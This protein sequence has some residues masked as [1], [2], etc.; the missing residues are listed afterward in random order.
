MKHKMTRLFVGNWMSFGATAFSTENLFTLLS[1]TNGSGK[2]SICDAFSLIYYAEEF[3]M[4]NYTS[5][6]RRHAAGAIHWQT[7]F[8]MLRPGGTNSYII[9]EARDSNDRTY[10]QGLFMYS[11]ANSNKVDRRV[12][13][14]GEGTLEGIGALDYENVKNGRITMATVYQSREQAFTAFF[15]R[16]GYPVETFIR[17][18]FQGMNSIT[19]FRQMNR[20]ILSNSGIGAKSLSDYA[21]DNIFPAASTG[22]S[23]KNIQEYQRELDRLSLAARQ[24]EDKAVFLEKIISMG[25]DN[26][27]AINAAN[28][29]ERAIAH[30]N[31]EHYETE[32]KELTAQIDGCMERIRDSEQRAKEL[33]DKA[34]SL[35]NE[36]S[37]LSQMATPIDSLRKELEVKE[38][39]LK[40]VGLRLE[41]HRKYI[42]AKTA[43]INK[44]PDPLMIDRVNDVLCEME[45]DEER[46]KNIYD[47]DRRACDDVKERI[48][49]LRAAL[50]GEWTGNG[51]LAEM[52]R[53]AAILKERIR[54][55]CPD[56]RPRFLYECIDGVTDPEWQEAVERLLGN[57]RFG[58]IVTGRYYRRA[59]E[60]QHG[61]RG[62]KR[63]VIVLNTQRDAGKTFTK[64]VPSV[65]RFNDERAEKYVASA[66]GRYVLCETAE[67]YGDAEYAIRKNG[68]TK[69]PNRSVL[70]GSDQH[71]TK[72][73]GKEAIRREIDRLVIRKD[74]LEVVAASSHEDYKRIRAERNELQSLNASY[75][76]LAEH[77]DPLAERDADVLNKRIDDIRQRIT[78]FMNS[79][80]EKEKQAE[81]RRLSGQI[82]DMEKERSSVL[83]YIATS[84]NEMDECSK[85]KA[86]DEKRHNEIVPVVNTLGPLTELDEAVIEKNGWRTTI[87]LVN[88]NQTRQDVV[89]R[90]SLSRSM[91]NEAFL[92][93]KDIM[94]S[95]PDAPMTIENEDQLGWFINESDRIAEV[96]MD[97]SNLQQ[98]ER[99]K[100]TLK[101]QFAGM[102]HS[103]HQDLNQ[104]KA[105]RSKFNSFLPKYRIGSCY[106]RLGPIQIRQNVE[107]AR[108]MELAEKQ[109]AGGEQLTQ[110][111]IRYIDHVFT[112]IENNAVKGVIIDPFDYRRYIT[113][114]MEYR[115]DEDENRWQNADRTTNNNSAGQQSILRYILK[116]VVLASQAYT[117]NSL[118]V[119]I[120]DEVLQGVDDTNAAFFF[121]SIREMGVQCIL[122]SYDDRFGEVADD[123]YIFKLMR[124]RKHVQIMPFGQR[125]MT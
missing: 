105:I 94:A 13:F 121:E 60:I 62:N 63:T 80:K 24:L 28:S 106:Y 82:D 114:S 33:E 77:N 20:A 68:Q 71:V 113:T 69:A 27:D 97:R 45:R 4:L 53:S 49:A 79:E 17:A 47:S 25:R 119:C 42:A 3:S 124:D 96:R 101:N 112:S 85:K 11:A 117:E 36:R 5:D 86:E 50:G 88:I 12:Y 48:D 108:L 90:L 19:H 110:D 93:G 41:W 57:D 40:S 32:I 102:L 123:A 31:C 1:G 26:I 107:N 30:I 76:S 84:K 23:V 56:A 21:K 115:T 22:E 87:G 122:A 99:L 2:T 72:I 103:M 43:L 8:G 109:E 14:Q 78:D 51:P 67:E 73:L 29:F 61:V 116:I 54:E 120:T 65:I 91:V 125:N 104:A 39:Q 59:C 64:A 44:L 52:F 111:D 9:L 75:M 6:K 55:A 89:K 81:I 46:K 118:R 7:G 38:E 92:A 37:L 58:I 66:Y 18:H 34:D 83:L 10:H 70:H 16:R 15:A 100:E 98:I 74:E 95:S 35:R